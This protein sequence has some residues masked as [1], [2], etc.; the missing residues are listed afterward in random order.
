MNIIIMNTDV[1][2]VQSY[3]HTIWQMYE[4]D[5]WLGFWP[6]SQLLHLICQLGEELLLGLQFQYARLSDPKAAAYVAVTFS[7][8]RCKAVTTN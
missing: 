4:R 5:K 8:G 3:F 1:E 6:F 7:T 2:F